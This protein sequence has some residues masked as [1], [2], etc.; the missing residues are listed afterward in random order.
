M[1]SELNS[2]AISE[3]KATCLKMLDQVNRT[4]APILVTKRGKPIAMVVPPPPPVRTTTWLGTLSGN[5]QIKGDIISPVVDASEW[6][7]LKK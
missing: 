2:V 4:G 6:E 1:K 7:V 3:F 5:A